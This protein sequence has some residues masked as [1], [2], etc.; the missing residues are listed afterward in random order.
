M[1]KIIVPPI[2]CQGIKTKLVPFIL[3]NIKWDR[4]GK[5]IEPFLGSGVVL[6]NINPKKALASDINP[7]IIQFYQELQRGKINGRVVREYLQEHGR[8][9]LEQGES[10]YYYIRDRFNEEKSSLDFLFL[11][12]A[13]FNGVMRFNSKGEFNTPFGRNPKRFRKAYITK[14]VNQVERV[15]AV[16]RNKDW[17]FRCCDW[18][19]AFEEAREGDFIYMDPPYIGRH[20]NYYDRWTEKDAIELAEWAKKSPAGFALSMWGGN[21]YRQNTYIQK[22]WQ[23]TVVRYFRHF[24]HVGSF[25]TLRHEMIEALVIKKGYETTSLQDVNASSFQTPLHF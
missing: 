17:E 7:Y 16:M 9:L 15:R 12:R 2:K 23:G 14:I 22:Y 4:K 3:R 6:F 25:E 20:T 5:W 24:Y 13:C 18:K 11:S 8:K 19:E 21:I 10:Y 1:R